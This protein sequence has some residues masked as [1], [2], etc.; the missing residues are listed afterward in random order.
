MAV[1]LSTTVVLQL[2]ILQE[3]EQVGRCGR[4]PH[5]RVRDAK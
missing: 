1:A 4:H 2:V 5:Q 3:Q